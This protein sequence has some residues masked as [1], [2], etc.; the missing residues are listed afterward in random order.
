MLVHIEANGAKVVP[1]VADFGLSR[2][3][4]ANADEMTFTNNQDWCNGGHWSP[5]EYLEFQ[6]RSSCANLQHPTKTGDVWMYSMTV[7]VRVALS[8]CV[9]LNCA[10]ELFFCFLGIIQRQ[11]TFPQ[12]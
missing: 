1:K 8:T 11:E 12:V 10:H 7:L 5:P 9:V 6:G 3:L 2:I 4:R